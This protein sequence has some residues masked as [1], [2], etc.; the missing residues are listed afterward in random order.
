MGAAM[1]A[2]LLKCGNDLTVFDIDAAKAEHLSQAGATL[3]ES[4]AAVGA[5]SAIVFTSLPSVDASRAVIL[6]EQDGLLTT[7]AAGSTL[8]ELSTSSWT[9]TK[10]VEARCQ[11]KKVRFLD[12]PIAGPAPPHHVLMMGGDPE[13]IEQCRPVL[14]QLGE[15]AHAGPVGAGVATKLITNYVA[16][17]S[18]VAALEATTFAAEAEVR[19]DTLFDVTAGM[20]E[21]LT[22]QATGMFDGISRR[23][24]GDPTESKKLAF[25]Y[26]IKKDVELAM[27]MAEHFGVP[28]ESGKLARELLAEAQDRG[29]GQ[30]SWFRV[31]E[32]LEERAN[33]R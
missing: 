20:F 22:R 8:V 25:T 16:Y 3:A 19:L 30:Y 17:T 11:A 13:V 7:M 26:I 33:T 1:A 12:S 10:E 9:L 28:A 29:W 23:D 2:H 31:F 18:L 14:S 21:R 5:T 24:F 6:D 15:I 4:P 32:I 27:E